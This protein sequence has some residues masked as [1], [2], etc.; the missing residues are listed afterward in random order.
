[1]FQNKTVFRG[2]EAKKAHE[3]LPDLPVG[4]AYHWE[5]SDHVRSFLKGKGVFN[6]IR[7]TLGKIEM[8][9]LTQHH[10]KKGEIY[11]FTV[12]DKRY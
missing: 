12:T 3:S 1:M 7:F 9:F 8:V 6:E 5:E 10:P 11:T 2:E 4:L